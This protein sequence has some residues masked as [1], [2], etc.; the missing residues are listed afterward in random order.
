MPLSKLRGYTLEDLARLERKATDWVIPEWLKRGNTGFIIGEPKRANKS[1]LLLNMLW[2]L[3][4]CK[5][6]WA[7]SHPRRPH[8]FVPHR[9]MRSVYFAQEDTRDDIQD[10]VQAMLN[11]RQPNRN[12]IIVPKN[13]Q[14]LLDTHTGRILINEL[15]S[16]IPDVDVIVFDTFRRVIAGSE[17]DSESISRLYKL[18]DELNEKYNCAAIFAH[19]IVKPPRDERIMFDYSDPFIGRGSGDIF[20]AGDAFITIKPIHQNERDGRVTL[21]FHAKR[22]APPAPMI[23]DVTYPPTNTGEW[24]LG[25]PYGRCL[26]NKFT[27]KA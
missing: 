6:I 4:E 17:S 14:L 22:A 23:V 16:Q 9:P 5:P 21:F 15:L 27:E 18:V 26:F 8:F 2:D 3:S 19:H 24:K 12:F 20:G 7:T 13:W 25:E 10:R 1:W 11:W